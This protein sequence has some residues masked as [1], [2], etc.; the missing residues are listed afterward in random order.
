MRQLVGTPAEWSAN[1]IVLG[2][3]EIGIEQISASDVRMK[4]G[5]GSTRWSSLPYAGGNTETINAATQTALNAKVSISG[6]S[7]TGALLLSGNASSALQAVPK[8]QMD[9]AV[10]SLS[11]NISG[12]VPLSGGTMTGPLTL[13]GSPTS[14]LHAASKAYVDAVDARSVTTSGDT[15]TGPL[16]LSGDPTSELHAVTKQYV[17]A[18]PYQTTVGGSP[19]Y[20]GKVVKLNT[21]GKIDNSLLPLNGGYIGTVDVTKPY[22]LTGT[23]SVGDYFAVSNTGAVDASWTTKINGSPTTAAAGQLLIYSLN[24]RFDLV[25]DTASEAAIAGKV[26]KSGDTMTGLLTLSG[27]PTA[28][29][30]AATKA[31]ADTKLPLAGGTLTGL[32][33]LSG[34][35]TASLHAATKAYV[36]AVALQVDNANVAKTGDTMTGHLSLS[37][38]PVQTVHA[39]PKGYVDWGD[40]QVTNAYKAADNNIIAAF[41]AADTNRVNKAGD[42]MTGPLTLSANPTF[43]LHAATKDYVDQMDASSLKKA[44]NL[45]DL[46]SVQTARDNLDVD[47]AG[48]VT[49]VKTMTANY[50]LTAADRGAFIIM[51]SDTALTLV[52][53]NST[54]VAFPN[55]TRVEVTQGGVGVTKIAGQTGVTILSAGGLVKISE[56]Y[57]GV[58]LIKTAANVWRVFGSLGA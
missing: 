14:S 15:M 20:S 54:N 3:G 38:D 13:S 26:N 57:A 12:M 37:A 19:E 45:A 25:G 42:T 35:P 34:S 27:A 39:T 47:Q 1:N 36:D 52:I 7:M 33:T 11:S 51:N 31:Y 49:I 30:H 4:V 22:A 32:L 18:G 53:P 5:N 24:G 23:Y 43:W 41:Q 44:S 10:S 9:A 48:T 17:D 8:Q 40:T 28:A 58:T 29:M 6:S 56:R 50:T 2:D 55:G 46:T 21:Q 16:I